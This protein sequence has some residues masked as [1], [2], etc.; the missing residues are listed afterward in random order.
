MID[1]NQNEVKREKVLVKFFLIFLNITL[2]Y[3]I[4]F[5][6][7]NNI[8]ILDNNPL[9]KIIYNSTIDLT[10]KTIVPCDTIPKD[11]LMVALA[12]GQSNSANHGES[13]FKPSGNVYSFEQEK[14]FL[15]EDP[16]S[17]ATG[18]GGSVWT[19]LGEKLIKKGA[20]E[21]IIFISIGVGSSNIAEWAHEG[22]LHNKLITTLNNVHSEE[23]EFTHLL[24]HQG[25][26]DAFFK[27]DKKRYKVLFHSMLSEIRSN[28]VGAPILVSV[29]TYARGNVNNEIQEAQ[30]ELID[31]E[32]G[33]Y[34][35]P[36]TDLLGEEYRYDNT[37]FSE[38][39]F[40]KT[41]DL[42]LEKILAS[43]SSIP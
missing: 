19:R 17:D 12:F 6:L 7:N 41:A 43:K 39:G 9:P 4:Y 25:E 40:N 42:W 32:N 36:N 30:R 29:A 31:E 23:L 33:I 20:Y 27:R 5:I 18:T 21:N 8:I 34:S 10:K 28:G 3:C 38:N 24:W 26:T 14:C 16:L 15:A 35:G 22:K 13:K 37:H 11:G 2:F 1:K